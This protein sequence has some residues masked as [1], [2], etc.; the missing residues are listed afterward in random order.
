MFERKYLK[1][2][3]GYKHPPKGHKLKKVIET[4]Y[5][6]E[7]TFEKEVGKKRTRLL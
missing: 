3:D 2:K 7:H 1:T 5:P 6:F 4:K